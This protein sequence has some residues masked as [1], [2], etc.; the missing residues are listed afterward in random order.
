MEAVVTTLEGDSKEVYVG[1]TVCQG[2]GRH[3]LLLTR[4]YNQAGQIVEIPRSAIESIK[5]VEQN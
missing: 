2:P 4:P 5:P 3:R 1:I